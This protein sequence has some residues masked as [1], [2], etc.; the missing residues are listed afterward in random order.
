MPG[1]TKVANKSR[2]IALQVLGALSILPYPFV[3]LANIMSLAAPGRT[4]TTALVWMLLSTYP[5]VWIALDIFAWR[6]MARGAVRRA[7]ALSSVPAASTVLA[8]GIY[9]FSWVGFGL[10]SVGL[11]PGGLHS[12]TYPSNNEVIDSVILAG[13]DIEIGHDPTGSVERALRRVDANLKLINVPVAPYGSALDVALAA[14]SISLDGRMSP[15]QLRLQ[16]VRGLLARGARLSPDEAMDLR[17]TWLLRRALFEG[18]VRTSDENPLVWRIITHNRGEKPLNP[19]T[20]KMPPRSDT[21]PPFILKPSDL[22]LLNRP[23]QLHGTPL[24]AALLDNAPDVC[25]VI[26]HAGGK[27]SAG[28]ERDVAAASALR[29]LFERNPGLKAAYDQA[30]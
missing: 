12:T 11:G 25:G 27:L 19:L 23:T 30:R 17:K 2:L 10:G 26:I 6:A 28:E 20:D 8:I 7:F 16:L 1:E 4:A 22:P 15:Q 5:I 21:P 24:Y 29:T 14:L 3:L 18:P 9:V 13:K